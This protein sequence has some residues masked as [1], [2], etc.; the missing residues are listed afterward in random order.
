MNTFDAVK[1]AV[2]VL[3]V[4]GPALAIVLFNLGIDLGALL[5]L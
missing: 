1:A 3:L 4:F 5:G 2:G